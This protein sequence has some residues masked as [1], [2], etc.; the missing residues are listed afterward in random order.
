M[1]KNLATLQWFFDQWIVFVSS[2][3]FVRR[4][5]CCIKTF[6]IKLYTEYNETL[7]FSSTVVDCLSYKTSHQRCEQ[8]AACEK[9]INF[10]ALVYCNL[11][12]M[13]FFVRARQLEQYLSLCFR[14]YDLES[15]VLKDLDTWYN[16]ND[17]SGN[18]N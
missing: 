12:I 5:S 9:S 1:T 15:R 13:I 10:N 18:I 17:V 8:L 2:F 16:Y 11:F 6:R 7:V 4:S 3:S 14:G